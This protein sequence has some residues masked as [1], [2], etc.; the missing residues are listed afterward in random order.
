M[1]GGK[2]TW[3]AAPALGL[4]LA[5][6][7]VAAACQSDLPGVRPAPA[8][9][10]EEAPALG[11]TERFA[12]DRT[13]ARTGPRG[14]WE[15]RLWI[16]IWCERDGRRGDPPF[17][18]EIDGIEMMET[19]STCRNYRE[20]PN[21]PPNA[22]YLG[23]TLGTGRHYLTIVPPVGEPR[24]EAIFIEDDTW[25]IVDYSEPDGVP[26]IS[27]RTQIEELAVDEDYD[28]ATRPVAEGQIAAPIPAAAADPSSEP[29]AGE[30][31]IA[32]GTAIEPPPGVS[33]EE[34]LATGAVTRAPDSE[35]GSRSGRSGRSGSRDDNTG[36]VEGT[37]GY[38]AVQSDRPVQVS[39][40]GQRLG[41]APIRRHTLSAGNHRVVL[42]GEDGFERSFEVTI[43]SNRTYQLVNDR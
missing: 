37:P 8:P 31:A 1:A 11:T 5:L 13:P 15:T 42:R 9:E 26:N 39:V 2:A 38:L 3:P 4:I 12:E 27:I 40:D 17:R 43:E 10:S 32:G 25:A 34:W 21:S 33:V 28:P 19:R 22:G 24:R 41:D 30:G 6:A 23:F 16:G 35:G 20:P 18:V 14:E 29:P 36:W 7:F